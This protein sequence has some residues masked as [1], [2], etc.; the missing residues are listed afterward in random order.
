MSLVSQRGGVIHGSESKAAAEMIHAE[1]PLV[2]MFGFTTS[3][4][5]VSQGRAQLLDGVLAFR[6]EAL[7]ALR[8]RVGLVFSRLL[9]KGLDRL[10]GLGISLFQSRRGS[11]K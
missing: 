1:A 8:C 6:A 9:H 7:K 10:E 5:S 4:R 2:A 11:R 3:L